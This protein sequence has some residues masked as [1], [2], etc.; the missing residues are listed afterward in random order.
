MVRAVSGR[1]LT[2]EAWVQYQASPRAI[3][4]EKSGNGTG[5]SASISVF[6]F[7][8]HSTNTP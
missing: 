8:Y 4:G 3:C 1:L 2:A 5:F 7:Q 6:S